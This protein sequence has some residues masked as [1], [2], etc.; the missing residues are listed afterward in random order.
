MSDKKAEGKEKKKEEIKYT[1]NDWLE[2][3]LPKPSEDPDL[4]RRTDEYG[5]ENH[6]DSLVHNGKMK[7]EERDKINQAKQ[8]A[9]HKSVEINSKLLFQCHKQR[10]ENSKDKEQYLQSI[11]AEVDDVIDSKILR[12]INAGDT[13][14]AGIYAKDY[15]SLKERVVQNHEWSKQILNSDINWNNDTHLICFNEFQ[16]YTYMH[17]TKLL[18]EKYFHSILFSSTRANASSE[19]TEQ[20]SN[21]P[22]NIRNF[23][24]RTARGRIGYIESIYHFK[25]RTQKFTWEQA[26][27]E[28]NKQA[29][30]SIFKH[31]DS[32]FSARNSL[33]KRE[34]NKKL[35]DDK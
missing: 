1:Y 12:K 16:K 5:G 13:D 17:K 3:R 26:F 15:I 31:L 27:E 32:F 29:G 30:Y 11:I 25:N 6:I 21:K 14:I 19:D 24:L 23:N 20:V 10:A 9:F 7:R 18:L 8:K 35:K 34:R 33:I 22:H 2:Y 4:F 28:A